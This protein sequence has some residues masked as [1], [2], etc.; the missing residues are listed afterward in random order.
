VITES[1]SHFTFFALSLLIQ[2]SAEEGQ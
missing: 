1:K 2:D